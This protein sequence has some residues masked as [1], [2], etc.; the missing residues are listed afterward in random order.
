MYYDITTKLQEHFNND[1]LVNTCSSGSIFDIDL[2]KQTI[3]PLAHVMVD[4]V[5]LSGDTIQY[6]VNILCMDVGDVSKEDGDVFRGN[7]NEQ[8]ILNTQLSILNKAYEELRRGDLYDDNFQVITDANCEP[9]SDRFENK[10]IG[11]SCTFSIV[12][13]NKM[14]ICV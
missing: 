1:P 8:D 5:T 6:N 11:W 10:L 7:D 14:T 9:F 4:N 3:F 2:T 13:P 12:T